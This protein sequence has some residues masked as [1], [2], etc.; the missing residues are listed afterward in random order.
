MGL[1]GSK[2]P[3]LVVPYADQSIVEV[4]VDPTGPPI[5]FIPHPLKTDDM[6]REVMGVL[7]GLERKNREVC[8]FS[9]P[10]QLHNSLPFR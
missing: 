5:R 4:P 7:R 3:P 1:T 10:L 6:Q 9:S 2:K 8:I